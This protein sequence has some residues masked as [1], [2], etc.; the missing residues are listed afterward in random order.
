MTRTPRAFYVLGTAVENGAQSTSRKAAAAAVC[1]PAA[2]ECAGTC[3]TP[4]TSD[5]VGRFALVMGTHPKPCETTIALLWTRR[6]GSASESP[7]RQA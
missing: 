5:A 7:R 6:V 2:G 3:D 4:L 1:R